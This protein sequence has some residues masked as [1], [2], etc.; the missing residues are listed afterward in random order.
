MNTVEDFSRILSGIVFALIL[1]LGS[2]RWVFHSSNPHSGLP[3]MR[4]YSVAR[5]QTRIVGAQG[6]FPSSEF[7]LKTVRVYSP[8]SGEIIY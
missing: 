5:V 3:S 1:I 2:V 6:A 4:H 7:G 8:D